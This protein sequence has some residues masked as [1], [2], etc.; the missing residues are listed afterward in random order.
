MLSMQTV[1]LAVV[2]ITNLDKKLLY[3]GAIHC[4]NKN[5]TTVSHGGAWSNQADYIP[6]ATDATEID[7]AANQPR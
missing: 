3:I 2:I 1:Y 6:A 7:S 5:A 4:A